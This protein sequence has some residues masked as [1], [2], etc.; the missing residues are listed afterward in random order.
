LPLQTREKSGDTATQRTALTMLLCL[1]YGSLIY[2]F[3]AQILLDP[4]EELGTQYP[5]ISHPGS[6]E[7]IQSLHMLVT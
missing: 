4:A 1:E 5:L 7:S 2:H 3:H 6:E